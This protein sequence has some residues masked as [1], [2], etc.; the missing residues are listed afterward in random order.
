MKNLA[1][2][3]LSIYTP[4]GRFDLCYEWPSFRLFIAHNKGAPGWGIR[5]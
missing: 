4:Q 5:I 2:T 1:R 3:I